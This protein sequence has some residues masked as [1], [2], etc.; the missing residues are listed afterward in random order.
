MKL[1]LAFK[2]VFA[3][4]F[5]FAAIVTANAQTTQP[6]DYGKMGLIELSTRAGKGDQKAAEALEVLLNSEAYRSKTDK[7]LKASSPNAPVLGTTRGLGTSKSLGLSKKYVKEQSQ[8]SNTPAGQTLGK[9]KGLGVA[10]KKPGGDKS[11]ATRR[12]AEISKELADIEKQIYARIA[13]FKAGD[14]SAAGKKETAQLLKRAKQL[15]EEVKFLGAIKTVEQ[16]GKQ[17]ANVDKTPKKPSNSRSSLKFVWMMKPA[18][19]LALATKGDPKAQAELASRFTKGGNGFKKD[20]IAAFEWML[21]AANNGDVSAQNFTASNYFEGKG[22]AKNNML[23]A[24]WLLKSAENGN[25]FAQFDLHQE[26]DGH[27]GISGWR[28]FRKDLKKAEYW[29]NKAAA[30]NFLVATEHKK[31]R[32]AGK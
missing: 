28:I 26:F 22:V 17:T 29:L 4:S 24:Q 18:E 10:V 14:R 16:F 32:H 23:A 19:L 15:N 20:P 21:K 5:L 3:I 27:W 12:L 2:P 1:I 8:S 9:S 6:P 30:Q 13:K 25:K 31:R 11:Y 7:S